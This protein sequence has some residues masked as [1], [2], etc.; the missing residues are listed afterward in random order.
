MTSAP[1]EKMLLIDEN[2]YMNLKGFDYPEEAYDDGEYG[3]NVTPQ[4]PTHHST[5]VEPRQ[6]RGPQTPNDDEPPQQPRSQRRIQFDESQEQPSRVRFRE[7]P[8]SP[9]PLQ[10]EQASLVEPSAAEVANNNEF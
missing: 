8:I 10:Q 7:P 2:E 5:P 3:G 6:R 4:S 9:P 1:Y